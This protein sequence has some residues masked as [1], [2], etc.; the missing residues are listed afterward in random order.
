MQERFWSR[1]ALE[2]Q[3]LNPRVRSTIR[4]SFFAYAALLLLMG[5]AYAI[6]YISEDRQRTVSVAGEQLRAVA[7]S[8]NAQM[9]AMLE[10][11]L[12]SAQ[13]AFYDVRRSGEIDR[14]ATEEIIEHLNHEVTGSYIRA[15]FVG[16]PQRTVLVGKGVEERIQGV[17][18]WL[19]ELP[20]EDGIVVSMPI[21]DPWRTGRS[22]IPLARGVRENDGRLA[23]VGMW[24]DVEEL[25][26]RYRAIGLERGFISILRADGWLL[27]GTPAP[28]GFAPPVTDVSQ[29]ELFGRV[30]ALPVGSAHVLDGVS[31][32]DNKRK[33]FAIAKPHEAVPLNLVVSREYETIIA[34]WKRNTATVLWF[35]LGS[36]ALLILMTVLL[37]R[38]LQ[39]INRRE[40]QIHKLFENSLSSILLLKD[41]RIVEKN[42]QA[43][44]MFRLPENATLHG[45]TFEEISADV[46]ADGTLISEAIGRVRETLSKEGGAIFKWLFKRA[47]TGEPFEAEVNL[48]TIYV[49]QD[50]ITLAMIQDISEREAAKRALREMNLQLEARVAQRTA[51]LQRANAQLAA[52]NR[53]L[54][55]FTA[56]ASHDLR[57]PLSSISGQAGLL[58]LTYGEQL[59][60]R[61]RERLARIQQAVKRAS[62]VIGGLLSLARITRQELQAETVSLSELAQAVIEELREADPGR[63]ID[64]Y[65]Q[66][67]MLVHADRGLMTSLVSNLIGNAWKYSAHRERVWISFHQIQQGGEVVYCVADHGAGFSMEQAS[68]LFQAFRRLHPQE[69]FSGIGLGLATVE[70]IVT[71]Y[72]GSI[73]AEAQMDVGA[74][75]FFTL[76][77]AEH[78]DTAPGANRQSARSKMEHVG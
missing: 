68:R 13:S 61:G 66:P 3:A 31:A 14:V 18:A 5:W 44:K 7:A 12:G 57:S 58:E 4:R 76:P 78:P 49:G 45:K 51:E 62:D 59:G 47:D 42:S 72:G 2:P 63:D 10:D 24:F 8:L 64:I 38:F 33:L 20:E 75:F 70:R 77:D 19:T 55:E 17:P 71:R 65:I 11:G 52:T 9:E 40:G 26:D 50:P 29:S 36:S 60:V 15:L 43:R 25:L 23:W 16:N 53:A 27:T 41:H 69:Q 34:P 6:W 46:Q 21:H 22:V 28:G 30:R 56:S 37:Y 54:E 32:L 67:G 73:R 1:I 39:E 74:K 35:A 48:S